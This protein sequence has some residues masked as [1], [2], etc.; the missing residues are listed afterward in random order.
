[1][2]RMRMELRGEKK[3]QYFFEGNRNERATPNKRYRI[4]DKEEK[5]FYRCEFLG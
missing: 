1:M 2:M 4:L 3:N 5:K